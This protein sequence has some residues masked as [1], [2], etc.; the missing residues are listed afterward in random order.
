MEGLRG[1][2]LLATAGQRGS[3][4]GPVT[5]LDRPGGGPGSDRRPRASRDSRCESG[6]GPR[7]IPGAGPLTGRFVPGPD[8]QVPCQVEV[9]Q[10]LCFASSV[11]ELVAERQVPPVGFDGLVK[12]MSL[13]Q[14]Q[15]KVVQSHAFALAV[16]ELLEDGNSSSAAGLYVVTRQVPP[17][18]DGNLI[19]RRPRE[20]AGPPE[21][22]PGIRSGRGATR[23]DIPRRTGVRPPPQWER[24]SVTAA[25]ASRPGCAPQVRGGHFVTCGGVL[26]LP[27]L[28]QRS[29]WMRAGFIRHVP[30]AVE[31]SR[32]ARASCH[33]RPGE[34]HCRP[35]DRRSALMNGARAEPPS[36]G[37][38]PGLLAGSGEDVTERKKQVLP[39][40]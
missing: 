12:P 7:Q 13:P 11:A 27:F 32:I 8:G 37:S 21:R 34:N 24:N 35:T 30:H 31:V 19:G 40:P 22:S 14:Y 25:A 39:R 26:A 20:C 28:D 29:G 1:R 4:V 3:V 23:A 17:P 36:R 10:R 18:T 16:A 5:S 38:G 9:V 15:A 6:P 2:I 33:G